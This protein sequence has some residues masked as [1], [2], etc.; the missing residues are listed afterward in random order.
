M[1][2]AYRPT[3]QELNTAGKFLLAD[4]SISLSSGDRDIAQERYAVGLSS[5]TPS[6]KN[7]IRRIKNLRTG[8]K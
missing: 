5:F 2:G 1:I 4:V 6:S 3:K 8:R 7:R